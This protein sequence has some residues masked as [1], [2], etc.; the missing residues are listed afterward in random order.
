[1]NASTVTVLLYADLTG[2]VGLHERLSDAEAAHAIERCIKR[3]ERCVEA[4]EGRVEAVL[5]DELKASFPTAEAACVAA[6]DIQERIA[7]LPPVSGHHL[8]VR[9][10]LH[11]GE[12]QAEEVDR[13]A[14][15]IT[16]RATPGEILLSTETS[17]RLPVVSPLQRLPVHGVVLTGK[18]GK[19][20]IELCRL[21]WR[22][23]LVRT[24]APVAVAAAVPGQTPMTLRVRLGREV[25]RLDARKPTLTMGRD[26]G[27]DLPLEDRL[28]SRKHARIERRDE[29]YVFVDSSTNGSFITLAGGPEVMCRQ[30]ELPL[31]KPG[32]ICLGASGND[33][34]ATCLLLDFV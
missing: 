33:P 21:I 5:G 2:S 20:A 29:T 10:G 6:V 26:P 15:H 4:C 28:V 3:I 1:M 25:Y 12:A 18:D 8:G 13:M 27:C 17:A 11:A 23:P 34:N 31:D 7:D 16:G 30:D 22:R 24:D 14:A 19:G 32:R 9:I